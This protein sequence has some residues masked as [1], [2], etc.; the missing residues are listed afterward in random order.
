MRLREVLDNASQLRQS[1]A[2]GDGL[3]EQMLDLKRVSRTDRAIGTLVVVGS[4]SLPVLFLF[5]FTGFAR[6]RETADIFQTLVIACLSVTFFGGQ[7]MLLS[8]KDS[9]WLWAQLPTG[10]GVA[11]WMLLSAGSRY[12]FH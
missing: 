4:A 7:Y 2:S 1:D 5:S 8:T 10:I 6:H 3:G 11:F 12:A 9:R